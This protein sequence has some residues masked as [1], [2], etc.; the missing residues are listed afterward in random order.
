MCRAEFQ[1]LR[2]LDDKA[3]L[4]SVPTI[5]RAHPDC[6]CEA[7]SVSE[8]SAGPVTDDEIVCR[9]VFSTHHF[10]EERNQPSPMLFEDTFT[11]GA[12]A[13]RSPALSFDR[14][15]ELGR[16]RE[17]HNRAKNKNHTYKGFV[18]ADAGSVRAFREPVDS[19][20]RRMCVYD[21]ALAD[22]LQHID[23][24][25]AA[26]IGDKGED[27]KLRQALRNQLV[28]RVFTRIEQAPPIEAA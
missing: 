28:L 1:A 15:H 14:I 11:R 27:R 24:Y 6:E 21:T 25:S 5:A 19:E 10:D 13:F 16:E 2:A 18:T 22:Q 9:L 20:T 4:N 26:A 3:K 8:F 23:V 12:S 17:R 7:E